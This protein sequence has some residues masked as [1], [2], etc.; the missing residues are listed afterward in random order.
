V[1]LGHL[2]LT[3]FRNYTTA[4]LDPD[5]DGLTVIQGAN[6]QGKTNLLEAVGY[7][8]TLESFRGA[9]REALV[10]RGCE[11][12]IVRA[13]GDRDSRTVLLEAELPLAGRERY[14]LNHQPLRRGRE[15]LGA[16]RVSVF[17]P[18]DLQIVQG[19]PAARRDLLDAALVALHPRNDAL[20]SD[21]DRVLRQRAAL[22]RQCDGRLDPEAESTLDVWDSK[23]AEL[24]TRW[25][26]ERESTAIALGPLVSASYAQLSAAAAEVVMNY[27]RSWDGELGPALAAARRED[28]R[29]RVSTIGPHR[30][31][32]EISLAGMPARTHASQGEQRG[33]ALALRLGVHALVGKVVGSPPVLL[34]D[35]VF[36][37]LDP[38][39]SAALVRLL[40]VGQA[41]LTTAGPVPDGA[42]PALVVSVGAG[43]VRAA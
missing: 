16:L 40:P 25:A 35:D 15:L 43:Q 12:A 20:R 36:S 18:D 30:D 39:R 1:R 5:P 13:E 2:W 10:R 41:L 21:L 7:L 26:A 22:L 33:L 23:L 31:E 34:L 14:L 8:A 3:D 27:R 17:S 28:L 19:G 42:D 24:G 32:L 38:S 29:R 37:E 11:R 9:P 6:G 4:E